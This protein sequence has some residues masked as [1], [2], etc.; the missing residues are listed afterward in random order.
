[1]TQ[2]YRPFLLGAALAIS[3]IAAALPPNAQAHGVVNEQI[4]RAS[5]AIGRDSGNAQLYLKRGKLLHAHGDFDDAAR[6][7]DRVAFLA[8]QIV[9]VDLHRGR[10]L[11][12]AGRAADARRALDRYIERAPKDAQ[13]WLERAR[14]Q[15]RLGQPLAAAQDYRVAAGLLEPPLPD[16]YLEHAEA[17]LSAGAAHRTEALQVLQDGIARL[18]PLTTLH[19]KAAE[20]ALAQGAFDAAAQRFER[21][22]AMSPRK[23]TWHLRRGDALTQAQRK[24]EA[25]AAYLAA[26]KTL[27]ALPP[28]LQQVPAT[29]ELKQQVTA[30][31]NTQ[32]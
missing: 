16:V 12:D 21:L 15:Q 30:R 14:A 8:P 9:E 20:I 32:P 22:A 18:G 28:H 2:H 25:H 26:M 27:E 7:L 10:L 4:E 1:M 6:D 3:A 31:L 19:V 24:P 29:L 11:L 5:Q 13:G 23:E 17:L